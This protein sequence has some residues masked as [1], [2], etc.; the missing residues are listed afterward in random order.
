MV[1][2]STPITSTM[3][4]SMAVEM[5]LQ[6]MFRLL[7]V[8]SEKP[9]AAGTEHARRLSAFCLSQTYAIT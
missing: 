6:M 3:A 2:Q 1:K 4:P 8:E 9:A 7:I 5:R